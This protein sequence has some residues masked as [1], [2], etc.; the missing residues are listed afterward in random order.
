[1]IGLAI[2]SL[3]ASAAQGIYG[4]YQYQKGLKQAELLERPE[5]EIPEEIR[6]NLTQAQLMSLEG[7]PTEQKQQFVE[8]VQRTMQTG[9]RGV[10][11]RGMGIAGIEGLAQ[12]QID[13]Y[14]TL[15]GQD[16]A[17]RQANLGNLAQAR[18]KLA[19]FKEREFDINKMQ[20]Y[21]QDYLQAQAMMGA[22]SQNIMGGVRSGLMGLGQLG[23]GLGSGG[24]SNASNVREGYVE[25]IQMRWS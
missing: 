25:P 8:N 2:G 11:E 22:G 3:A 9:L 19:G 14:R 6:Q 18:G 5:Y 1:M 4:A 17:D 23:E 12:Q 15:L 20:P 7:L 10:S 24:G 16:V 13:A 21:I